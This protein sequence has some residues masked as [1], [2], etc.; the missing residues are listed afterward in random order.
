MASTEDALFARIEQP[1]NDPVESC[2][3]W[4]GVLSPDGYSLLTGAG[5][6]HR[7][8]YEFF[9][10]EIPDGLELD[11]LCRVRRCVNPWH[12][13]PVTHQVNIQRS[14][15]AR[16][17]MCA[18]GLHSMEGAYYPPGGGKRRCRECRQV[19][20]QQFYERRRQAA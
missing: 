9:V 20:M 10:V 3:L 7:A 14:W 11:H 18:K 13:D 5:R 2:W 17:G 1:G 4:T 19:S 15:A 6:A 16:G 12:M 8:L